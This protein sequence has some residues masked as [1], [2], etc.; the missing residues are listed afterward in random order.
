MSSQNRKKT[1]K[2]SRQQIETKCELLHKI[3]L[4]G[5]LWCIAFDIGISQETS[6]ITN[7]AAH[8]T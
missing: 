3:E 2:K 1:Q 7:K 6:Q 8:F 5:C 4:S